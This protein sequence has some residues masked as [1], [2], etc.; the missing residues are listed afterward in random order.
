MSAWLLPQIIGLAALFLLGAFFSAIE[1]ALVAMSRHRLG[2]LKE[3][4]APYARAIQSW[5]ENPNKLLTTMLI[6]INLVAVGSSALATTVMLNLAALLG[7]R[8]DVAVGAST[9]AVA[10]IV[11]M[12]GEIIP[13]I[14]AIH[15]PERVTL[16]LLLPLWWID[17]MLAPVTGAMVWAS[18]GIIRL[19]GGKPEGGASF[20]TVAEIRALLQAGQEQGVLDR[21]ETEMI[22]GIFELGDTTAR[23]VMVPRIDITAAGSDLSVSQAAKLMERTGRSRIPVFRD[24]IDN[25]TGI[26]YATDVN[27]ALRAGGAA[28]LAELARPAHFVPESKRLDGLLQDFKSWK[29][30]IAIVVDEYGGTAGMVTLEDVLEEIVG[31][32]QDEFDT[33]EPL[34]RRLDERSWRIDARI[35]MEELNQALEIAFP[36]EGFETFGGFI[37]DIFGKVPAAREKIRWPRKQAQWEFTVETV[38]KRRIITVRARQL[39]RAA[40]KAPPGMP[41]EQDSAASE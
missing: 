41:P 10:L 25:I 22:H 30:H 15:D 33:E 4:H 2:R 36:T 7:W 19:F 24:S 11:I 16:L 9:A 28:S 8:Q 6:G 23:E 1:T 26:A 21:S 37:Y 14:V 31:D 3:I 40:P 18:N 13:K 12:F 17:R 29:T 5:L 32:V 20:L 39:T 27:R 34:Y 38:R 35:G